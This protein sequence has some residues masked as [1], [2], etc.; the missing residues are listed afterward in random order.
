[1]L[2]QVNVFLRAG[3]NAGYGARW[4]PRPLSPAALEFCSNTAMKLSNAAWSFR[5]TPYR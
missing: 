2:E 4:Y 1:M 5:L 3:A